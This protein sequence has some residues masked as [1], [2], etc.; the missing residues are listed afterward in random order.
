MET[1]KSLLAHGGCSSL[2]E[3]GL[4]GLG[5]GDTLGED[6][7]VFALKMHKYGMEESGERREKRLTA[8]SFVLSALRRFRAMRWRLC[9]RRWGVTK[10]W[11]LGAL[12]YGFL[13]SSFGWTSRRMTNLRTYI[14]EQNFISALPFHGSHS[15]PCH[16]CGMGG[17]GDKDIRRDTY[18]IIL[19]ETEELSDL[20]GALGTQSLG[21][22]NV[23]DAGDVVF[24][25]LDDGESQ[26]GQVHSNNAATDGF[27]LA[28][29]GAARAEA[30]MTFGEEKSNTSWMHNTLL[31]WETLLVVAAG[32]LEDVAFKFIT[33]TV[34]WYFCTHSEGSV[35]KFSFHQYELSR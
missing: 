15:V 17:A 9:C 32:D 19:G 31:H 20:G 1:R 27:A 7:G 13:L 26:N 30:G 18:I 12:V 28:F 22:N 25:L 24:A 2:A 14:I 10:R 6:V 33:D 16:L 34:A 8:A 3:L 29:T 11:I 35:R 5:F 21:V 23:G 4:L